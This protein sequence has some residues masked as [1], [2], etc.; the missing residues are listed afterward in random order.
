M[1]LHTK[2]EF[3][4][5]CGLT[6]GNLSVYEK[7][8]KVVY[9]GDYVDDAIEP[10]GSFLKLRKEKVTGEHVEVQAAAPV[11]KQTTKVIKAPKIH[12]PEAPNVENEGEKAP[13]YE[14]TAKKIQTQI[15]KMDMEMEKMRLQNSKVMG[16]LIPTAMV[17]PCVLQHNQSILTESKNT[18]D[19]IM[20]IFKKK[21]SVTPEDEAE[22]KSQYLVAL[23]DMMKKA[24][25]L[26]V[27]SINNI[28]HEFAAK[29]HVGE[30]T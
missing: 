3:A 11:V 30:R 28:V 23:N 19:D 6:T 20:R 21:Y 5:M 27:K 4:K 13:V 12:K 26:T 15:A 14:L 22:M 24:T 9:S 29:R 25:T 8:G 17:K 7:R 2:K 18:I 10:N 16:E 1:A